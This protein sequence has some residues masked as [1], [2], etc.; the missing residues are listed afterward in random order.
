MAHQSRIVPTR[1]HRTEPVAWPSSQ[2]PQAVGAQETAAAE[3]KDL[4]R[5]AGVTERSLRDVRQKFSRTAASVVNAV[6][7]FANEC[8]LHFIGIVAGASFVGGVALRIWRSKR[9]A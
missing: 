8:P 7:T 9:Y 4:Y 6:R 3:A 2:H 5:S 1:K